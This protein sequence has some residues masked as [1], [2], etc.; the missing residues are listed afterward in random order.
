M[1][2]VMRYAAYLVFRHPT[3][4]IWLVWRAVPILSFR[5]KSTMLHCGLVGLL[6]D[7]DLVLRFVGE[8]QR[9]GTA[10][11]RRAVSLDGYVM[12]LET[13]LQR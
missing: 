8:Q 7:N 1:T 3:R 5:S 12:S 4:S 2:G 11:R 10:M 13:P 9:I 6:A